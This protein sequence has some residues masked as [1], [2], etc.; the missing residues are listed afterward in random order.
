MDDEEP[1]TSGRQSSTINSVPAQKHLG[2]PPLPAYDPVFHWVTER[3]FIFGQRTSELPASLSP[4][5]GLKISVKLVSLNLQAGL[6][7][8]VYGTMCLYNKDTR[9]KLSEDFHFRFLPS[10]F[11]DVRSLLPLPVVNGKHKTITSST[12]VVNW[13]NNRRYP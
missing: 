7:E 10:D 5:G 4:S 12:R 2:G 11:Q 1:S 8:P 3:A 9:E 6:V 13:S